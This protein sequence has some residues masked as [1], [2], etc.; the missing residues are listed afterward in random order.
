[1]A[2]TRR[3]FG[4]LHVS[5]VNGTSKAVFADTELL[6]RTPQ[7]QITR[8]SKEPAPEVSV[9]TPPSQFNTVPILISQYLGLL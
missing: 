2:D 9:D 3:E 5:E 7:P 6:L 1:M 4:P 8:K